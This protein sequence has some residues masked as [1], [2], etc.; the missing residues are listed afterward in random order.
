MAR[1]IAE[2]TKVQ[3]AAE[4]SRKAF[5]DAKE[6][7]TKSAN[8][9]NLKAMAAAKEKM[10]ASNAAENR[11]RFENVIG[12]R[13]AKILSTVGTLANGSN[14]RSYEYDAADVDAM[15]GAIMADVQ[16]A[17]AAY[18]AALSTATTDKKMAGPAARFAFKK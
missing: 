6:K 1:K 18:T 14:R 4:A 10:N 13:V 16:K 2:K 12:G 7:H 8:E 5:A 11:A 9:T 15:F 3:L 17:K